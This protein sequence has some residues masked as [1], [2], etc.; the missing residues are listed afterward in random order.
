MRKV[1]LLGSAVGAI[2][3]VA[4]ASPAM[5]Q[6]MATQTE[7]EREAELSETEDVPGGLNTII[8]TAQRRAESLQGR[9][10]PLPWSLSSESRTRVQKFVGSFCTLLARALACF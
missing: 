5:A 8:V 3:A 9:T 2:A 10:P 4:V 6:D 7:A 1:Y